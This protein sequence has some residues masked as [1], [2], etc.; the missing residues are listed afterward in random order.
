[1]RFIESPKKPS[2]AIC[3]CYRTLFMI[4]PPIIIKG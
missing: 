2:K 1:M 3:P 4:Y